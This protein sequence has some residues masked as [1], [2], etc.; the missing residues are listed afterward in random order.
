MSETIVKIRHLAAGQPRAYAD[1]MYVAEISCE[2][3]GVYTDGR[4]VERAL[5]EKEVK[6]LARL[7]VCKFDDEPATWASPIWH[8][9]GVIGES[10]EV[11][12]VIVAKKWRVTIRMAYTD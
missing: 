4:V 1:S 11:N 2:R 8:G 6:E 5:T 10:R 7:F 9:P 3:H 12:G